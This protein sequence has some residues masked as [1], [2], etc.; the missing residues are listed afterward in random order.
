M[1]G[2]DLRYL[3]RRRHE[4]V[5]R[6]EL[7]VLYH[8]E[9]ER[10]YAFLSKAT[11]AFAILGGSAAFAAVASEPWLKWGG[12]A[13]AASSTLS[14]VFGWADKARL[15]AGLAMRYSLLLADIEGRGERNFT[16]AD[17]NAWLAEIHRLEGEEPPARPALVRLCQNRLKQAQGRDDELRPVPLLQR[18]LARW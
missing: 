17:V 5:H 12:L 9:R 13:V 1:T 16:E 6:A 18:L 10:H 3:W 4:V 7:S 15:H 8:R 2:P 14:L 11:T